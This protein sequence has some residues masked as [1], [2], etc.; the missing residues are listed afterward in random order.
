LKKTTLFQRSVAAAAV[1]ALCAPVGAEDIDL[2]T[3]SAANGSSPNVILM[4]DNSA[5]WDSAS[6]H[7]PPSNGGTKQGEAELNAIR[8]IIPELSD[9]MNLGLMMFTPG[10][11]AA[12]NGAY[13]RF[14]VRT[15]DAT[16]KAA[17]IELIGDHSCAASTNSL[18]G[19][20]NCIMKNFSAPAEKVGTAK[21]D[22]SAGL[23]EVFKYLGGFTDPA[24]A[25]SDTGMTP[26]D[27]TH[28]GP[29]RYANMPNT[30]PDPNADHFAYT[31][32]WSGYTSP[33]DAAG[34]NACAKNYL[35][36]IG[37]GFPSQD[38]PCSLLQGVNGISNCTTPPQLSMP[39]FSSVA[40]P[41]TSTLGT[42][43]TCHTN[44]QCV[45]QATTSFPGYDSYSCTGG[46]ATPSTPLG[47]L[48]QCMD[49]AACATYAQTNFPGHTSYAC[50]GGTPT[51]AASSTDL[52]CES[53]TDCAA[54]A[55]T[56]FPG[57]AASCTGGTQ[58][59]AA[60]TNLGTDSVR[61]TLAQCKAR[62]QALFPGYASYNCINQTGPIAT[63]VTLGTSHTTGASPK[64]VCETVANCVA[65]APT[66]FPGNT[67]YACGG[68][69]PTGNVGTNPGCYGLNATGCRTDAQASSAF[70]SGA[71]ASCAG[72]TVGICNG[73]K[74]QDQVMNWT[75]P[76]ST[77]ANLAVTGTQTTYG[78]QLMVATGC[79][80]N[81]ASSRPKYTGQ[82][83]QAAACLTNQ[84]MTAT[85]SC[86]I[87]QTMKG[88]LVVNQ[89]TPTNTSA[90]PAS[91][92]ARF[93][94]EWAKY[95]YT[96]D[97]SPVAGQQN[98]RTY[99]IDVFKDQQDVDETALLMSMAKY[100]GGRYFQATNENA[101][102]NALR[103]ILVEIQSVNS[104]FAATSLPISATNRSQNENQV[105][106]GMFRPDSKANPRWFGNLKRY[107]VKASGGD[108]ALADKDGADALSATTGFI[109]SCAASYYT[110]DSG[111][112]TWDWSPE[113]AGLCSSVA[114]SASNDLPDGNIVEK[115][116]GAEVLRRGNDPAATAPF[117]V[118]RRMKT[119]TVSP[120]ASLVDFNDT[121]VTIAR[122]GMPTAALHTAL[123][124]FAKGQDVQDENGNANFTEPRPSIHGDITHSRPL[125]V[126]FGG[127]RGVE[128]FYGSNDG[129]LHGF[130]G[131]DGREL[132][133]FIAPEH[134]GKLKR[135]YDN[136]PSVYYPPPTSSPPDAL[137]K[138]Y[139]F[140]GT[141]GIVQNADNSKVWIYPSMR[142]G[143]RMVYSFDITASGPPALKWVAGCPNM[144]D[145]VGCTPNVGAGI[146]QTWST[147]SAAYVKGYSSGANPVVIF[148][149]GYDNCDDTDSKTSTCTSS[150][151]GNKV[152]ILDADT[153]TQI[154]AFDTDRPVPADPLLID[155][156]FDGFIDMIYVVDTGGSLYRVDMIDPSTKAA[157]APGAWTI[158]KVASTTGAS[159]K[160]LYPPSGLAAGNKVYLTFGSGDRERPL[161]TNYPYVTP[162]LNR[163]YMVLDTFSG[164]T[165]DLDSTTDMQDATTDKGCASTLPTGKKGWFMDL[166]NGT[167]EQTVTSS[168]IFGG[169]V[170]FSTNHPTATPTNTC[171]SNLGEARGYAVNLINASGVI[172]S[173][174]LCGGDRSGKFTGGGLAPSPVV[175]TVSIGGVATSVLIGG[176]PAGNGGGG[177]GGSGVPGDASFLD[178]QKPPIPIQQIRSRVYW[179]LHGDQ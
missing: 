16:N 112:T 170:F 84:T 168:V 173:G 95:L 35:V 41:T 28:F 133:S 54:R 177:G 87:N 81:D 136:A 162:I 74:L 86:F 26:T 39:Q 155:R 33:I 18:N 8:T 15:M 151:K 47:T 17:F 66:N 176:F 174:G 56:A 46:T 115:G 172:G 25:H 125:P 61:E 135:L 121:N 65:N 91:N 165:T 103:Q 53:T 27:M 144:T 131:A 145:D 70:P 130:A 37:N 60:T 59:A 146:G 58:S 48:A 93:T 152:Y 160:F 118:N 134:H 52:A 32:G 101:I 175:G 22:Y 138:D 49:A 105:F 123:I 100:G 102:L 104:V 10:Q 137:R 164:T 171:A 148:G 153:G 34:N 12:P 45:S 159:R 96:T 88:T 11:G 117:V 122:T 97:V 78:T 85:D 50:S 143:G 140:D 51:A 166:T 114:N 2:F 110:I 99:T 79:S 83:M 14:H 4:I 157:R 161:I 71:T 149:G 24:H 158:T 120:C 156:D 64:P 20:A 179:Y 167:G 89:V 142:R 107:Q 6:Q 40:I 38:A 106:I 94:D 36:F 1:A 67:G 169:T 72:G 113:S 63:P 163:F 55:A 69:N 73:G 62:A 111:N 90:V 98:V 154:A 3:S 77:F 129:A 21:L 43:A 31:N 23:F 57:R 19:S 128:I 92:K 124:N 42:D 108:L 80:G 76:A 109:Q 127:T 126:N 116:S 9:K 29:F 7:W 139:F 13:V 150:S 75:C 141:P 30:P 119:C 68:G 178:P 5:N 44:A 147:P 82:I 132:W